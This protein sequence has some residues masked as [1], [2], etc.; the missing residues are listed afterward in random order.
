MLCVFVQRAFGITN[1]DQVA[2]T[3]ATAA[4]AEKCSICDLC[5]YPCASQFGGSPCKYST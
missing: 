4:P 3:S 2:A 5:K 1:Q